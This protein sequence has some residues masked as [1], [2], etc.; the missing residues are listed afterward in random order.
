MSHTPPATATVRD[1]LSLLLDRNPD[2]TRSSFGERANAFQSPVMRAVWPVLR[3]RLRASEAAVIERRYGSLPG[4]V[5]PLR[6]VGKERGCGKQ[7]ARQIE[8]NALCKLRRPHALAAA[9]R[10]LYG[11]AV[12]ALLARCPVGPTATAYLAELATVDRE[13]AL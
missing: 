1:A 2:G 9:E 10:H 4:E 7:R 5:V 11:I 3:D 6:Q 13:P 8:Q 12:D